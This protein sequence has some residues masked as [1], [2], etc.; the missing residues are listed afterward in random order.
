MSGLII[1]LW[2]IAKSLSNAANV[3]H[4]QGTDYMQATFKSGNKYKN[5]I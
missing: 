3:S 5:T 4:A 1:S 2:G